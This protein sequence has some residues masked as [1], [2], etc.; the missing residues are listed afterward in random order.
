MNAIR[1]RK[2][3]QIYS[4]EE[5][6]ALALL[7]VEE[8]IAREKK[9]LADFRKVL[10]VMACVCMRACVRVWCALWTVGCARS[11]AL[12]DAKCC[13]QAAQEGE[14]GATGAAWPPGP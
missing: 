13:H 3:S 9:I 5:K 1:M 6:R 8:K 2:E 7:N 14:G 4:A 12:S 10:Q 11:S